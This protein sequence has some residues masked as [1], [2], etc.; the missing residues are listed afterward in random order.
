MSDGRS[1][2][3]NV[4]RNPERAVESGLIAWKATSE[5]YNNINSGLIAWKATSERLASQADGKTLAFEERKGCATRRGPRFLNAW[6]KE[7][8]D[9]GKTPPRERQTRLDTMLPHRGT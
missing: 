8:G 9:A 5:N 2:N 7:K 4:F 6:R 3:R 1:P